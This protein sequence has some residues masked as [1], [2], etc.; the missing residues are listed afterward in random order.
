[1]SHLLPPSPR[2]PC[3]ATAAKM[4]GLLRCHG[5]SVRRSAMGRVHCFCWIGIHFRDCHT[6]CVSVGEHE[7]MCIGDN[8]VRRITC[9][10]P[11]PYSLTL[12]QQTRCQRTYHFLLYS[13]KMKEHWIP[14]DKTEPLVSIDVISCLGTGHTA[15]IASLLA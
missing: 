5:I 3:P 2:R 7:C 14:K 10:K 11:M 1:M 13:C 12:C 4:H 6:F 15:C 9:L 8:L